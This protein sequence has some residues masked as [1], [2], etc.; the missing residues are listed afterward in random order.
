MAVG[1]SIAGYFDYQEALINPYQ[2]PYLGFEKN[3]DFKSIVKDNF[4]FPSVGDNLLR[5]NLISLFENHQLKQCTLIDPSAN[6]SSTVIV[7][8]STYIGKNVSINAQSQIGKGVIINTGAIIEH[9]C[10]I[11]NFS[12]IA[13]AAVLCGNVRIG[14]QSF[15]GANSVVRN[16]ISICNKVTIGSGS[17]I[18]KNIIQAGV[19]YGNPGKV[20]PQ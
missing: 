13:P 2:I 19:Y 5:A 12:H 9:E 6:V 17:A 1:F 7:D 11:N 3:V 8:V 15:V 10:E 18:V 20:Q 14:A 16:N 4:V